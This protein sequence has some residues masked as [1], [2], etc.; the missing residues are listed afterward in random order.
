[1]ATAINSS[2][3]TVSWNGPQCPYGVVSR[4]I[5][6]YRPSDVVQTA[7]INNSGYTNVSVPPE[8]TGLAT[9]QY[10]IAR[11]VPDTS[12]AIHVQAVVSCSGENCELFG[13]IE[14]EVLEHSLSNTDS[15]T[16]SF[17]TTDSTTD[18]ISTSDSSTD[19]ISTTD[20][21][22]DTTTG[23]FT[24]AMPT[25]SPALGKY[26]KPKTL[27]LNNKLCVHSFTVPA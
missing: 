7:K 8:A 11:L 24:T 4:Y 9:Q 10:S 22:T 16:D 5:V 17:S 1:M 12:Y 18:S 26:L 14:V 15:T 23:S 2:A 3:I 20:R 13:A 27:C 6:Y 19:S 21:Y 25:D